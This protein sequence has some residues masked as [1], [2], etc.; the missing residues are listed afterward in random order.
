MNIPAALIDLLNAEIPNFVQAVLSQAEKPKDER[1][2]IMSQD[3]FPKLD[4]KELYLLG[5]AIKYAGS[6]GV[7][8]IIGA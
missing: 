2:L 6:K 4:E 3:A 5:A 7:T 8:V 1:N